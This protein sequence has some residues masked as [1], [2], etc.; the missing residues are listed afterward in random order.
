[1]KVSVQWLDSYNEVFECT[2]VKTE[3]PFLKLVLTDG[4]ERLI[5]L[6]AIR[7][8]SPIKKEKEYNNNNSSMISE[9]PVMD[10]AN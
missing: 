9:S 3:N 10:F 2:D 4:G 7:Y 8:F 6:S 5:P 1:M